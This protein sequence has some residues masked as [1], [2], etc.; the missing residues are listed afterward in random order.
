M[1]R[2]E[3]DLE[4]LEHIKTATDFILKYTKG[5]D[6]DLFLRD[7]LLKF[8][9][10]K[11]LEIIGEAANYLGKELTSKYD[12]IDWGMIISGRN[13]YVH[14]YFS[15]DWTLIWETVEKYILKFSVE[16]EK[17]INDIN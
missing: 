14:V 5:Y 3:Y 9:V 4:R 13:Y 6:Q 2:G 17:I 10:L 8:A 1:K 15:L 7:E 11:Q 12:H 16:I